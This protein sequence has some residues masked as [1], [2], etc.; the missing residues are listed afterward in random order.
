MAT[1]PGS[2]GLRYG[3]GF[4]AVI[5]SLLPV[6][7]EPADG[8]AF[9][10]AGFLALIC[11][12]DTV[13]SRIP[14]AAVLAMICASVAWRAQQQ[15][16]AGV[17]VSA[18]GLALGF[19]LLLVPYLMGGMGAGDVKALAALG[20][21]LGP[22]DVFGVFLCSAL[23]GGGLSLLHYA[24][25]HDL[26]ARLRQWGVALCAF[27]ATADVQCLSPDRSEPLR[28][29]YAASFA[30]GFVAYSYWWHGV[31]GHWPGV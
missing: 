10:A 12:T 21:L 20:A 2:T 8:A 5:V 25:G 11:V 18:Q 9:L 16:L 17:A 19:A 3:V 31:I 23:A 24:L 1:R 6:L 30:F 4:L 26:G 27:A 29:P 28:F 22:W 15:G 14:N 7:R 13:R